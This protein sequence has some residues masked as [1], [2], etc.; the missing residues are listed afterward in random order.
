MTVVGSME[1]RFEPAAGSQP[2][3]HHLFPRKIDMTR[4]D[5]Y[6][7]DTARL[8]VQVRQSIEQPLTVLS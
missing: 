5:V 1:R 7:R 8:S 4:A 6:S 2:Q 3:H